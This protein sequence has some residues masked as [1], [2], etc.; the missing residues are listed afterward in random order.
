MSVNDGDSP[1]HAACGQP[2]QVRSAPA[3]AEWYCA[4][5]DIVLGWVADIEDASATNDEATAD[6]V[7]RYLIGRYG[8]EPLEALDV[9]RDHLPILFSGID[10]RLPVRRVGDEVATHANLRV[11]APHSAN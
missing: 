1:A 2:L 10:D 6:A 9:V 8:L 11:R 4:T 5:C 7:V 3:A